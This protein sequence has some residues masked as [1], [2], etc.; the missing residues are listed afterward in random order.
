MLVLRARWPC[1]ILFGRGMV[2]GR[3]NMGRGRSSSISA[4]I[5]FLNVTSFNTHALASVY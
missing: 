4:G 2:S 1:F 5:G 3:R